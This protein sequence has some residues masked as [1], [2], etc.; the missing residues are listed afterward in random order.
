MSLTESQPKYSC[1]ITTLEDEPICEIG[2]KSVTLMCRFLDMFNFDNAK[3][4]IIRLSDH[5]L[6]D[7]TLLLS[8][9]RNE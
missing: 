8:V 4:V 5:N 6:L 2:F 1:V 7:P 9:W 3:V